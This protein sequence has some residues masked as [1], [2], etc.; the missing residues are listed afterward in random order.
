MWMEHFKFEKKTL[1]AVCECIRQHSQI[2]KK[3]TIWNHVVEVCH[4]APVS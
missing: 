1:H 2:I 3:H 4:M